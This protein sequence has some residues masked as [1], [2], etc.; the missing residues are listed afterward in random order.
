M[1][2]AISFDFEIKYTSYNKKAKK[3]VN[4]LRRKSTLAKNTSYPKRDS[5]ELRIYPISPRRRGGVDIACPPQD[6]NT[7][8]KI[9]PGYKDF[10]ES[11]AMLSMS[12]WSSG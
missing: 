5:A 7:W 11:I 9:P 10:R 12:S 8:V 4:Y 2:R 6:Q 1:T 3:V